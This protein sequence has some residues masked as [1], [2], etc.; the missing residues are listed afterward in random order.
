MKTYAYINNGTIFEVTETDGDIKEMFHP[1]M[2]WV[3]ISD[4]TPRPYP[5]WEATDTSGTWTFAEPSVS[6]SKEEQAAAV[7]AEAVARIAEADEQTLGMADAYI[8]DLLSAEDR[9]R[10]IAFA[11]YKMELGKVSAQSGFPKTIT[12]PELP[13]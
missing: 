12:W 7:R 4:V 9:E 11:A 8:A 5:G 3:D 6:V 1:S 10:F 2:L 13:K